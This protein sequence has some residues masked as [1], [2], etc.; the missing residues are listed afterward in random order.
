MVS[1]FYVAFLWIKGNP[2]EDVYSVFT[3]IK[4]SWETRLVREVDEAVWH[5][6]L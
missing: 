2:N 5:E 6:A 4:E 1:G 3:A